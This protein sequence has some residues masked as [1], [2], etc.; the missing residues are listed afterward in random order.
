[1]PSILVVRE[2]RNDGMQEV[3]LLDAERFTPHT[4]QMWMFGLHNSGD[5]LSHG[6]ERNEILAYYPNLDVETTEDIA[7]GDNPLNN[8]YHKQWADPK[9]LPRR[10]GS[11]YGPE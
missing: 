8:S 3:Y 7:R 1:M 5:A 9:G 11:P 2:F 6:S 4:F 10:Y